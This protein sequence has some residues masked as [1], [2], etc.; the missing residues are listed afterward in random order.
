MLYLDSF[1]DLSIL[2]V[3]VVNTM[4]VSE[5]ILI[6][7]FVLIYNLTWLVFL[8]YKHYGQVTTTAGHIFEL[9]V[10]LNKCLAILC[11]I[12]SNDLDFLPKGSIYDFLDATYYTSTWYCYLLAMAGSQIETA[13]FLKTMNVNTMMTNTAGKIILAMSMF[14][15]GMGIVN[16]LLLRPQRL[17]IQRKQET[18][19]AL[20]TRWFYRIAPLSSV[21]TVIVLMVIV[22]ALFRSKQIR[23]T[24]Y[25]EEHV[26]VQGVGHRDT[27]SHDRL[28]STQAGPS[29]LNRKSQESPEPLVLENDIVLE[30]IEDS[31]LNE[32]NSENGIGKT[33]NLQSSSQFL[34][35]TSLIHT[36]NKYLKNTLISLVILMAQLSYNLTALYAFITKSG[37]DNPTQRVMS[38]VSNIVSFILFICLPFLVKNK[39]DRLSA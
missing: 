16:T 32:I 3:A 26:D 30:D 1:Q 38:E 2:A 39:L 11:L 6:D 15:F 19:E 10:L 29:E 18:C 5:W 27:P 14:S 21:V 22:F 4:A 8:T 7:L 34:T 33:E 24:S 20:S 35:K 28:F 36:V 13:I 12:L 9:N 23:R 31:S 17:N 37:C 25:N